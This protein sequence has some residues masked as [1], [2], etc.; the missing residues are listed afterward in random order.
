LKLR[1]WIHYT[2]E[3]KKRSQAKQEDEVGLS[4]ESLLHMGPWGGESS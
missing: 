1:P 4:L 2:Q 3:Q